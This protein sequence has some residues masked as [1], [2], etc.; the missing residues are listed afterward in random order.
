MHKKQKLNRKNNMLDD[1]K[2]KKTQ[3]QKGQ[4]YLVGN[5]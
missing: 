5:S 3:H 2:C 4:I 1:N